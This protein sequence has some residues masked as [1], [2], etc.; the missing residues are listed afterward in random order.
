MVSFFVFFGVIFKD[1]VRNV[2]YEDSYFPK[3]AGIWENG[4]LKGWYLFF[5]LNLI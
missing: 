3:K 1:F 5:S 2:N 4:I